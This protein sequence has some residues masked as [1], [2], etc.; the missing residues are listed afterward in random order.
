M[1]ITA[2]KSFY[3]VNIAGEDLDVP[4]GTKKITV[5]LVT[6]YIYA[7]L[8][9]TAEYYKEKDYGFWCDEKSEPILLGRVLDLEDYDWTIPLWQD[10]Q[11]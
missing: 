8:T 2:Y 10:C 9:F 1:K 6:G 7:W 3:T 4:S 11:Y 5:D